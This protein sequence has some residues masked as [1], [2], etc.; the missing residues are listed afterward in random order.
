VNTHLVRAEQRAGAVWYELAH[1]RLI[2]PVRTD[3]AAWR[4]AHLNQ[5]QK[6]A[7]VWEA[8]GRPAGLLLLGA[9][10][11]E[12]QRW[13]GEQGGLT[14][15]EQRFLSASVE[16][17]MA[18]EKERRQARRIRRLAIASTVVGVMALI[19]GGI[20]WSKWKESGRISTR[21]NSRSKGQTRVRKGRSG[22]LARR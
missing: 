14:E 20:A 21:R 10:L 13:A 16:A 17:Q 18:V 12:A 2:E 8:Q 9:E 19:A 5:V 6:R 7:S 11:A 1:D 22:G 15:V 4:D 3:N